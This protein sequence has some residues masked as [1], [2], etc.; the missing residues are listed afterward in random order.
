MM[1]WIYKFPLRLRSL[2]RKSPVEQELTEELRFHLEKL[3]E[4]K[5][6]IGMTPEDARYAA[7]RELGGVEQI[8]EECRDM[9]R[10]HYIENFVHD[11]RYGLRMLAK[12]PGFA[13]VAIL[14]L[15]LGIGASTSIFSIA[16]AVLLRPLPYPNPQ[17]SFA[18]GNRRPTVTEWLSLIRTSTTFGHRT[19]RSRVWR[20]TATGRLLLFPAAA[21]LFVST[22]S[23][24]PAASLNLWV[25]NLFAAAHL[26][27]KEQR[28]HGSPAIIV[29]YGY[30]QRYLGGSTDL[31][32]F[33]LAIE[34]ALIL[35]SIRGRSDADGI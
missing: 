22:S 26:H 19:T 5:V 14:T 18:S 15:A 6:A 24:F 25:S 20:N 30:W 21:S 13:A 32:N 1:R 8:K 4:E 34:G 3:I 31:S 23:R 2:F 9:R 11:V 27:R 17:Q 7:L 28:V 35:E 10:V 12:N 29:S 33:H 16:D